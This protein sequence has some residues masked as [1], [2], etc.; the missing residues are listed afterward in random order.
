MSYGQV[1][2][3]ENAHIFMGS[4]KTSIHTPSVPTKLLQNFWAWRLRNCV[5]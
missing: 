1:S 5:E 3:N 4:T 2:I